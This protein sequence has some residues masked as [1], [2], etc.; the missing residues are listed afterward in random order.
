MVVRIAIALDAARIANLHALSW[1]QNYRESFSAK[2]LDEE[3]FDERLLVWQERF[4]NP[5]EHQHIL[6]AEENGLLL[7]FICSYFDEN[8]I[9]GT[10]LD[11]LHVSAEAKGKGIGT[12]LMGKLAE[13]ILNSDYKNGFY[14]WVLIT[15]HAAISFY[16]RIGGTALET[17][18]AND[19]GD[20]VFQKIKYVWK[21]M[22]NFLNL[23]ESKKR[24]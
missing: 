17:V 24:I 18:E 11:N 12:L 19:I 13:E 8:P 6:L 2:F 21:D 4:K 9:Y 5:K 16:D 7:G 14:L 22:H 3:V 20:A 1:Q 10:Y 23:I 15:N